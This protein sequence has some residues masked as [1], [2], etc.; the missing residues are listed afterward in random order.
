MST[1]SDLKKKLNDAR[2]KVAAVKALMTG[3]GIITNGVLDY[4]T[5][6]ASINKAITKWITDVKDIIDLVSVKAGG[7]FI[8]TAITLLA[9]LMGSQALAWA[10]AVL[11][12]V[13][14]GNLIGGLMG[15]VALVLDSI[16]GCELY[17][18][19][20]SVKS[21]KQ[22]LYYRTQLSNI[23]LS[24]IN[25][26]ITLL[27]SYLDL[28]KVGG[29]DVN[30]IKLAIQAIKQAEQL[31]GIQLGKFETS[32]TATIDSNLV[33]SVEALVDRAIG[34]VTS[35]EFVQ[36][37]TALNNLKKTY[38]LKTNTPAT[39]FWGDWLVYFQGLGKELYS[40][41]A[42][43]NNT[44]YQSIVRQLL[45]ALP[46]L[47]Q[48]LLLQQM[49][50]LA[51]NQL[52]AKLPVDASQLSIVSDLTSKFDAALDNATSA[53]LKDAGFADSPQ[54]ATQNS[55]FTN[56]ATKD[57][58]VQDLI[59]KI[60]F[61]EN[62][63][64]NFPLLWTSLGTVSKLY[65][66]F[67][68]DSLEEL[69]A[70]RVDMEDVL[71]IKDIDQVQ[72]NLDKL[73][74]ASELT[75]A[76]TTLKPI[77]ST[78]ASIG[79]VV[80]INTQATGADLDD[81][82]VRGNAQ[83]DILKS[84]MQYKLE[85]PDTGEI[86]TEPA[87]TILI[88]SQAALLPLMENIAIIASPQQMRNVLANLQAIKILFIKQT[89]LDNLEIKYCQNVISLI[90]GHRAF[91]VIKAIFDKFLN[92]FG[93]GSGIGSLVKDL[94]TG[95]ISSITDYFSDVNDAADIA[96]LLLTGE[97]QPFYIQKLMDGLSLG[98]VSVPGGAEL[99]RIQQEIQTAMNTL[100]DKKAQLTLAFQTAVDQMQ[101]MAP[102]K[103]PLAAAKALT[104]ATKAPTKVP[105][106]SA[107]FDYYQAS[108]MGYG[109]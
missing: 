14:F 64:I 99:Q 95:D 68:N 46:N 7:N 82:V 16:P 36:N 18:Q 89:A 81:L 52:M 3:L 9:G 25:N 108:I 78:S 90:E 84:F 103:D 75:L 2:Q 35:N 8:L 45:A 93:Q 92:M 83:L 109:D 91:P 102:S 66:G 22:Q 79:N 44:V 4:S 86:R 10:D 105:T 32:T 67:L 34:Y 51:T 80:N 58:T 69:H 20:L 97:S 100:S 72:I 39:M 19:Y 50:T 48:S 55:F 12:D 94:A 13:I 30:N 31:L 63:I 96:S 43:E 104:V 42:G 62:Y 1:A 60:S 65:Q 26:V 87:Q 28:F 54:S 88:L 76:K 70:I 15:L 37:L 17:M 56:D 47:F 107:A 106:N 23:L 29:N 73:K 27:Q 41:Y 59:N 21:L 98:N 101:A 40:K 71:T 85:D 74:W 49:F 11:S 77:T 53:I 61:Y 38:D 33:S 57:L 24:D 6:L 5:I